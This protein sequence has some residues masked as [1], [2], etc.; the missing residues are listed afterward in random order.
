MD[1]AVFVAQ[2]NKLSPRAANA[3][4]SLV[5]ALGIVLNPVLDRVNVED[6]H[7]FNR[8]DAVS[9]APQRLSPQEVCGE[10]QCAPGRAQYLSQSRPQADE[11][12]RKP[13][14]NA[15]EDDCTQTTSSF[16][17]LAP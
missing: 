4:A 5:I 12:A 16:V 15:A 6:V 9:L 13:L 3:T 8:Q 1:V 2:S 7:D 17:L 10:Q 14:A 11:M